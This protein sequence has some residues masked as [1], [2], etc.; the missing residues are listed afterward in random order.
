MGDVVREATD[1][2]DRLLTSLLLL[3][4]T[5]ARGVSVH[6]VVDLAD[7]VEPALRRGRRRAAGPRPHGDRRRR[8]APVPWRSGAAGAAGRQPGGERG[9]AQRA[10]GLDPDRHRDRSAAT[11][12]LEVASS[13]PAVDPQTVDEL[14]EPFR[15]GHRARTGHRGTGLGLSIVR[16]VVPRT[17]ARSAPSRC[18]AAACGCWSNCRE[19]QDEAG[20]RPARAVPAGRAKHVL[21]QAMIRRVAARHRRKEPRCCSAR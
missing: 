2:A 17:A 16:A 3:A 13:G 5:Q 12:V 14:F 18:R 10:G 20:R 11:A 6:Q 21:R 7:L 19:S 8:P 15:Q 4:R 1:R 9:A